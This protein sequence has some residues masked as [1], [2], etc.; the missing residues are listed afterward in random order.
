MKKSILLHPGMGESIV[1]HLSQF[2]N[3]PKTGILAGQAVD[4][5]ITDLFGN[6]GGVYNDLDIFCIEESPLQNR[7]VLR[8]NELAKR[9]RVSMVTDKHS[10]SHMNVLL[11]TVST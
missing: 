6:G 7:N 2:G 3:L 10:Y 9:S 11:T 1:A 5:A 4:S 8:A